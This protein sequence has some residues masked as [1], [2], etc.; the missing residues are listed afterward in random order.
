MKIINSIFFKLFVTYSVL[1]I[2]SLTLLGIISNL[3]I[4]SL[5][6]Q[7]LYQDASGWLEQKSLILDTM[8][9]DLNRIVEIVSRD[10]NVSDFLSNESD[11]GFYRQS[12]LKLD[13]IFAKVHLIRPENVGM[14]LISEHGYIYHYG[15]S[16]NTQYRQLEWDWVPSVSNLSH[17]PFITGLH[18]RPYSNRDELVFS[19]VHRIWS[20]D[21]KSSG[22]LIIDFHH[23]FLDK[24][25]LENSNSK[26][27]DSGLL[28][29]NEAGELLYPLK[30]GLF[31]TEYLQ[32]IDKLERITDHEGNYYR[33]VTLH[34]SKSGWNL[35]GYFLEENLYEPIYIVRS[36]II[37]AILLIIAL[38]LLVSYMFSKRISDPIKHLKILLEKVS[39]GEFH[40]TFPIKRRDEIGALGSGYNHM[41]KKI[42]ELFDLVYEK[43]NQ[44]RKAEIAALQAQINPHFLYNTLEAINSLA[45]K[46]KENEIS[47]MIVLLGRLMRH[48]IS[49]FAET[50][51]I[52]EEL[53]Y[54]TNYIEIHN[55]RRKEPVHY[56]VKVSHNI[57]KFYIVKWTLQP[58]VENALLHGLRN[59][60][61]NAKIEIK[62]WLDNNDVY[63]QV[64]DNGVGLPKKIIRELQ[65]NL[66]FHSEQLTKSNK[67]G[68]GLYNVQSRI[69]LN[70]GS[71]YGL[72]LTSTPQKGFSVTIRIPRRERND[73]E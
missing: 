23:D 46:K 42:K 65:H 47:R 21:L 16:F 11:N 64:N 58:I 14:T 6:N 37:D 70:Y 45:R 53:T 22:L 59:G 12:F 24:L 13:N 66:D 54:I 51:P 69:R 34:H 49:N 55:F 43:Q 50:V 8:L 39:K 25:L 31:S 3:S 61:K 68:V 18:K 73:D 15:Y 28:I 33:L 52:E 41:I 63:V 40:H 36:S 26:P 27:R 5:L 7:K 20:S 9:N 4:S 10:Q 60:Q 71:K 56:S 2:I 30:N 62:A 32:S 38:C 35:T 29:I 17:S 57:R 72:L 19:Y 1:S 44:K 48:S 67:K